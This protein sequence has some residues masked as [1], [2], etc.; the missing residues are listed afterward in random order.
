MEHQRPVVP[1]VVPNPHSGSSGRPHK[2]P[3]PLRASHHHGKAPNL[4]HDNNH[5]KAMQEDL[6]GNYG[7]IEL[8]LLKKDIP[9][10]PV[11]PTTPHP[12]AGDG[13]PAGTGT[14]PEWCGPTDN[15]F[16]WRIDPQSRQFCH[17]IPGHSICTVCAVRVLLWSCCACAAFAACAR[18]GASEPHDHRTVRARC[19]AGG[20]SGRGHGK[21]AP[22]PPVQFSQEVLRGW[23]MGRDRRPQGRGRSRVGRISTTRTA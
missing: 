4:L 20:R 18:C 7:T 21:Q 19:L 12:S 16:C 15:F 1:R 17:W 6:I 11:L 5:V 10:V 23:C 13:G 14:Y 3:A 8:P 2:V 9:N 22:A